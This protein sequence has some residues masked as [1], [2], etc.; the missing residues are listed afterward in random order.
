MSERKISVFGSP[1]HN[2][3]SGILLTKD[4]ENRKRL[5][6]ALNKYWKSV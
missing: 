6:T 2:T 5:D 4:K 1:F 3:N